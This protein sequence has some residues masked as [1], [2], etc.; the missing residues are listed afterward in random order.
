MSP[1]EREAAERFLSE[2]GLVSRL[3][4]DMN[5]LGYV[6]EREA[7]LLVYLIATSRKLPR[8]LSGIIGSGSRSWEVVLGGVGGAVD[9]AGGR[10]A[11]FQV[12]AAGAV[13]LAR[14]LS[15]SKAFDA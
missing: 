6:G 7:K 12:D 4:A 15:V 5:S 11:V 9:A 14:G 8:P 3:Q 13:L 2:P 1:Q 10:G